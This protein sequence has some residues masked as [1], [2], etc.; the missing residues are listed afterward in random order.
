MNARCAT[1]RSVDLAAA[2]AARA[3]A[4]RVARDLPAARASH[5]RAIDVAR[6]S[7]GAEHPVVSQL[8]AAAARLDLAG[9]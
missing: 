9:R 8:L 1:P 3:E 2:F 7:A 4:E 6:Q 5:A